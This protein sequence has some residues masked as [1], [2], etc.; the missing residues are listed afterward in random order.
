MSLRSAARDWVDFDRKHLWHPYSAVGANQTVQP[1][2]SADGVELGLADG[3]TL[4]DGMSSWW[5]AIHGYNVPELNE[6]LRMQVDRFAHV[7]F[8]GLTHEPAVRLAE[9]LLRIAPPGLEHV[10]FAD[11]GS[12][13]VEVAL[14]MALQAQI[15]WGAPQKN[16]VVSFRYGYH[17]DTFGA[18]SVC[19]PENGMHWLFRG[20]LPEQ[21]FAEAPLLGDEPE[22]DEDIRAFEALLSREHETTAAVILEPLVQGAGG[23]RMYRPGFLRAVADLC[24]AHGVLLVL[25]EIATGF[26]RTGTMFA[27]EQA[28]VAPDILCVGKA[29]T[30]GHATLAAVLARPEI[31][32]GIR[33][34]EPGVLMH[35]PTFMA[36]PLACAVARASTE[37]LLATPWQERVRR[38]EAQLAAELEPCRALP[39]VRDVRVKGAIGVV[40]LTDRIDGED[41]ST[42]FVELGVWVRPFRDLIYVMPPYI[43]EA[44][45]LSKLTNAI[46]TVIQERANLAPSENP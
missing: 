7:M 5:C 45:P 36:N 39:R 31:N 16:R 14:K 44:E 9:L 24:R 8:G 21:Y 25:D 38:I 29:L 35:G 26:G 13:S 41:L 20:V 23:M 19:D 27:A 33:R 28:G 6:A 42:K 10:F 15:G 4:V 43:I 1:L 46:R 18:M 11:S 12:V 2:V 40:Q 22:T 17:G 37:L 3:R 30:G 34:S 32:E